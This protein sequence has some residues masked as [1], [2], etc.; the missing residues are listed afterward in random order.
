MDERDRQ[1]GPRE[2]AQVEAMHYGN[3]IDEL[4]NAVTKAEAHALM[5]R[6]AAGAEKRPN[7]EATLFNRVPAQAPR[8]MQRPGVA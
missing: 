3:M 8:V 6:A 1:V 5:P 7:I 2:K 4:I